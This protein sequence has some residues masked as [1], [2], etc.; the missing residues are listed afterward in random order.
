MRETHPVPAG[1]QK[2]ATELAEPQP[3]RRGSLSERYVKCSKPV[4]ATRKR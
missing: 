3:M 4:S 2:L 1:V